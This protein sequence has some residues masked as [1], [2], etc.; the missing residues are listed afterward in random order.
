MSDLQ[1]A[2]EMMAAAVA[3][4]KAAEDPETA[5][6]KQVLKLLDK[7][8]RNVR[9]FGQSN[10]VAQRFFRQFYE[11]L[12]H[13]LAAHSDVSLLVQRSELFFH[14]EPVYGSASDAS[15]ENLA[16]KLY[17]DGIRELTIHKGISEDDV[18]FF[19]EALWGKSDSAANDDDDIVT[20]LWEKNLPTIAVVTANE[21][22][23]LSETDTILS[24]QQESSLNAPPSSLRHVIAEEKT[25]ETAKNRFKSGVTGFEVSDDEMAALAEEVRA[26]SGRDTMAYLLDILTAILASE[27]SPALI[28]KLFTVY[29]GLIESLLRQG[30]W[31]VLE[32]ILC[33]LLETE[34]VRPDLSK[35]HKEQLHAILKSLGTPERIKTIEQY[36]SKTD[37]PNTDGLQTILA[38]VPAASVGLLC[39]L[40]GTLTHPAHQTIVA[41]AVALIGKEHPDLVLKSLAD[42]RPA[43]V[44]HILGIIGKWNNPQH[45]ESVEKILRYP[46]AGIRREVIRT[47]GHLRPQGNG[48]KLVPLL[49]DA[50]E[51]VRLAAFKLL[52]T[53][54]YSASYAAWEPLVTAPEFVSR[55]PAER[56]N[57]FHAMRASSGDEAVPYWKELLTDW[58]WT[59]RKQREEFALLAVDALKKLNT[60]AAR[61]A[62]EVGQDKGGGSTVK[63]AC[64]AALNAGS[65]LQARAS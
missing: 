41:D 48:T 63:Q 60:P 20:R 6:V 33:L 64:T 5:S 25:Q 12:T 31:F 23:K 7:A 40:L 36:L 37:A 34:T 56:R 54:Q 49:N 15:T 30:K 59:N 62:L 58:G 24:P 43:V 4:T 42:R 14:E 1:R 51:G 16:F 13:H 8:S 26:E 29:E 55:P 22:M 47:L 45:A 65:K 21:A 17:A 38:M 3:A 9:T 39:S 44:R 18:L 11:G 10:P 32:H 57:V 28:T 53:G 46:D 27:S 35:E 52:L 61:A 19:L 2:Q 50:D